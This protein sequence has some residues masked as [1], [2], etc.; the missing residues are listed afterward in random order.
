MAEEKRN[1]FN[2]MRDIRYMIIR[3]ALRRFMCGDEPQL[4]QMKTARVFFFGYS[5][6]SLPEH[7]I[8]TKWGLKNF[9]YCHERIDSAFPVFVRAYH[10]SI[11]L[12]WKIGRR[13][14]SIFAL[15]VVKKNRF[16]C[17]YIPKKTLRAYCWNFANRKQYLPNESTDFEKL[18]RS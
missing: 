5:L 13:I 3:N 18:K 2:M 11:R 9:V 14:I 8:H 10:I 7:M 17:K 6:I 15:R 1:K 16:N 4:P 12:H